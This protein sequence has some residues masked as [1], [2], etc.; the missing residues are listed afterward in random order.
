MKLSEVQ[1]LRLRATS[2]TLPLLYLRTKILRTYAS[3]HTRHWKSTLSDVCKAAP[4]FLFCAPNGLKKLPEVCFEFSFV[5]IGKS[6]MVFS[7]EQSCRALK[8][9]YTGGGP[10]QGFRR[11]FVDGLH[12][13]LVSSAT[14]C[15][16]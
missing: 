16:P 14:Q 11:C 9:W 10:E 6:T 3:K 2:H 12:H 15:F 8:S 7:T 13:S 1:L 5:L 4:I